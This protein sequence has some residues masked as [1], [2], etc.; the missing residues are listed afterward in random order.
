MHCLG[1]LGVGHLGFLVH[2]IIG[3]GHAVPPLG[4]T[5]PSQCFLDDRLFQPTRIPYSHETGVFCLKK[6]NHKYVTQ[7]LITIINRDP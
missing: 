1:I 3:K 4:P 6:F 7:T 2:R 5:R